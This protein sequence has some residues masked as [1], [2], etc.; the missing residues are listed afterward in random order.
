MLSAFLRA[1]RKNIPRLYLF[2]FF[3]VEIVIYLVKVFSLLLKFL[4][5]KGHLIDGIQAIIDCDTGASQKRNENNENRGVD[6]R[7]LKN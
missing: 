5:V 2:E 7:D 6:E 4:S 1:K 3:F